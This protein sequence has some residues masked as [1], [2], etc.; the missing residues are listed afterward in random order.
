MCNAPPFWKTREDGMRAYL[1]LA[2][3]VVGALPAAAADL[4]KIERV[5]GKEPKYQEK[6]KYCLLVFG[7]EAK[8]RVWLVLD[9]TALYVDRNGNGD[10]SEPGKRVAPDY[11]KD[12]HLRFKPGELGPPDGS[13]KYHLSQVRKD[14]AGY[15]MS[16][17]LEFR[18]YLLVGSDGPGPLQFAD[19][20]RD[21]PIIH[22]F[23]PLTL[24]RFDPQEGSVSCD[25]KPGPLVRG[26]R[27]ELGFTLGTPGLGQGTFAKYLLQKTTLMG[28]VEVRFA[29][30]KT[31]T[32][33]LE[34][35]Y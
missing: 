15:D 30:G 31:I 3:L 23:G 7:P 12:G 32:A 6:P 18:R 27:N 26:K 13:A 14:K 16:L 10:L 28:S 21:A 11:N 5:I 8:F 1:V 9:G 34:P 22:F 2:C 29:D 33:T 35:D 19:R 20:P 25:L 24:Q 4:T 17:R